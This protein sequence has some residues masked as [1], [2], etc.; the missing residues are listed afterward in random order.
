[1]RFPCDIF[2][3]AFAIMA[4]GLNA[5]TDP[6][7]DER[8]EFAELTALIDAVGADADPGWMDRL[9][10]VKALSIR[11]RRVQDLR[12]TCVS[13]YETWAESA[14]RMAKAR[15]QIQSLERALRSGEPSA[16]LVRRHTEANTAINDTKVLLD[17]AETMVNQCTAS[18]RALDA[19]LRK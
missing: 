5:C 9:D 18:R 4:T 16:A 11:S 1:M 14:A 19:Q 10:A 3:P 6:M 8:R 12:R 13:A 7:Q 17:S 15:K 2:L